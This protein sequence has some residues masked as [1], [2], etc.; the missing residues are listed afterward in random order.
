MVIDECSTGVMVEWREPIRQ[1]VAR[2]TRRTRWAFGWS[3]R[4]LARRA[5]VTQTEISRIERAL[6][7]SLEAIDRVAATLGCRWSLIGPHGNGRVDHRD[8]AHARCSAYVRHHLE[9][10]GFIVEQEVEIGTG[11]SRGWVDVLAFH[12]V[13]RFLH[14][15][16]IK[17]ELRDVGSVQRQVAWYE[18]EVWA[19]ARAR[20]WRPRVSAS[21]LYLLMT[22][23]N[24]ASIRLNR[25]ILEQA[26][27]MRAGDLAE[28]L[29]DPTAIAERPQRALALIDPLSRRL[30]WLRRSSIDGRRTEA[31]Y[32]DYADFM[33]RL[34]SRH[35]RASVRGRSRRM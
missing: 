31:P 21:G 22:E 20:G 25:A 14:V 35:A 28:V 5:G 12:P 1:D 15:G 27:P 23:A 2:I 10:H 33:T 8:H 16:E 13:A 6:S 4:E 3:Q 29:R 7:D 30:E 11:P 34:R 17:T 19:V 9:R 24:D 26:F 18:R 32:R